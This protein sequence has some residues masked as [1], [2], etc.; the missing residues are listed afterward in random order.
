MIGFDLFP[1]HVIFLQTV[2]DQVVGQAERLHADAAETQ[3]PG[4]PLG[5]RLARQKRFGRNGHQLQTLDG[6]D[7]FVVHRLL[8]AV[9]QRRGEYARGPAQDA[10]GQRFVGS[11][12]QQAVAEGNMLGLADGAD[13]TD[14]VAAATFGST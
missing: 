10:L 12:G 9:D 5:V 1:A 4:A 3:G 13:E 2:Q 11:E 7:R 8:R 6:V 14:D